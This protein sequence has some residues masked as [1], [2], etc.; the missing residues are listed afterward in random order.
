M[1]RSRTTDLIT[2]G[3]EDLRTLSGST[4]IDED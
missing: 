4:A 2:K 1:A 3:I